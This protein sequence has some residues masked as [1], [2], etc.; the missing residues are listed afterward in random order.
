MGLYIN[1]QSIRKLRTVFYYDKVFNISELSV[2]VET[3][4]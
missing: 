4:K 2:D 3:V 1:E